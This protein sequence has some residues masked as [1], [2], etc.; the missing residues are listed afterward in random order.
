MLHWQAFGASS[1]VICMAP[2]LSHVQ[3]LCLSRPQ[4]HCL[5]VSSFSCNG[6]AP[7]A[8]AR[9]AH[10][11]EYR[12]RCGRYAPAW[13]AARDAPSA[14]GMQNELTREFAKHSTCFSH[15]QAFATP[16]VCHTLSFI[17]ESQILKMRAQ[18]I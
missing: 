16:S 17:E 11:R 9:F 6:L 1:A 18:C 5:S 14:V 12:V 7:I 4:F 15:R 10:V 3:H 2:N 13:Q 8:L